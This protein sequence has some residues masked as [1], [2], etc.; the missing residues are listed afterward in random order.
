MHSSAQPRKV[1]PYSEHPSDSSIKALTHTST[2][3]VTSIQPSDPS[4]P[5]E[6]KASPDS[7]ALNSVGQRQ[8]VLYDSASEKA[9]MLSDLPTLHNKMHQQ[10]PEDTPQVPS[11]RYLNTSANHTWDQSR[12]SVPTFAWP[13]LPSLD[14]PLTDFTGA[15]QIIVRSDAPVDL[16]VCDW[17]SIPNPLVK[18]PM[19]MSTC[20]LL[21]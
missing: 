10:N 2:I 18:P 7:L 5:A 15:S 4:F 17:N 9:V 6:S 12:C 16:G 20:L 8:T 14:H 3:S 19:S 21:S 11:E 1:H 13:M